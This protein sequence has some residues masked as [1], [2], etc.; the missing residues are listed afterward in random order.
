MAAL[1]VRRCCC[2]VFY[3]HVHKYFAAGR[4]SAS[5]PDRMRTRAVQIV[6]LACRYGKL[7]VARLVSSSGPG[8]RL[9]IQTSRRQTTEKFC[10]NVSS[11]RARARVLRSRASIRWWC[12]CCCPGSFRRAHF[13]QKLFCPVRER[14]PEGSELP[15]IRVVVGEPERTEP[16]AQSGRRDVRL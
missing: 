11:G 7:K 12:C 2:G 8:A 10:I 1:A 15:A 4:G 13:I 5:N 9:V 14:T 6:A 16:G 3:A